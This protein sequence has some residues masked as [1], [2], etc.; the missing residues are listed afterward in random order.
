MNKNQD[1]SVE[2]VLL[3]DNFTMR[4]VLRTFLHVLAKRLGLIFR[5]H[6]SAD[7][8]QGLGYVFTTKPQ[9]IIVD[10]TLPKYSGREVI[11]YLATNPTYTSEGRAVVVLYDREIPRG[12]P[13]NYI[14]LDKG[15]PAFVTALLATLAKLMEPLSVIKEQDTVKYKFAKL[16]NFAVGLANKSDLLIRKIRAGNILVKPLYLLWLAIQLLISFN[17]SLLRILVGDRPDDNVGQYNQDVM[18]FRVQHYPTLV[19]LLVALIFLIIQLIGF[20][21]SGVAIFSISGR[22]VPTEAFGN[23]YSYR[24]TLTIDYTKVG[25]SANLT[26]FPVL[27]SGTYSYLATVGN[28]G[29][30]T[31]ANGY[32]IIFT[33]DSAGSTKLDHEIESYNATTGEVVFWVEVPSVSYTAN[34][35]I[36]MF[37]GNNSISTSQ[38]AIGNTWSSAHDFVWHMAESS[39]S[40]RNSAAPGTYDLIRDGPAAAAGKINGAQGF[41]GSDDY[42]QGPPPGDIWGN[43]T[44]SFTMQAQVYIIESTQSSYWFNQGIVYSEAISTGCNTPSGLMIQYQSA[45]VRKL[46]FWMPHHD[47]SSC[48]VVTELEFTPSAAITTWYDVAITYNASG[49]AM[50][51]YL[52]GTQVDTDTWGGSGLIDW[53]YNYAYVAIDGFG[54]RLDEVRFSSDVKTAG[55]IQTSYNSNNSPSTFYTLGAEDT[56]SDLQ[57]SARNSQNSTLLIPTITP[58][59]VG[60]TFVLTA[61]TNVTVTEIT[62]TEQGTVDAQNSLDNIKLV[63][64]LD[65]SAPYD[66]ASE[67][68]IGS[69]TQFGST[70]TDGFSSASG[71]SSFT[72]S[73]ALSTTQTMCVYVLMDVLS[74]ASQNQ[75][76]EI[77]ITDPSTQV[78]LSS[79]SVT[80][81]T[82][83]ALPGTTTLGYQTTVSASGSQVVALGIPVVNYEVG[84]KFA[85]ASF[86]GSRNVTSITITEQGTVDGQNN[87]ENIS[88]FYKFDTSAPY[89]C[90]SES[91]NSI[92]DVQFGSTDTN[93]FSGPNGTSTFTGSAAIST[94]SAMCVFVFLDVKSGTTNQTTLEI[95]IANPSTDVVVSGGVAPGPNTPVA[96]PGTTVLTVPPT[97]SLGRTGTQ[98]N[99]ITIGKTNQY[100]GGAFVLTTANSQATLTR[101]TLDEAGTVDAATNLKNI[102]MF[103]EIDSVAPYNCADEAYDGTETQ[104]GLTD[105]DGFSAT[106]GY[107][108]FIGSVTFTTSQAFCAYFV[109]D[110]QS[111]ATNGQ[112]L[113]IQVSSTS[114]INFVSGNISPSGSLTIVGTTTLRVANT[115]LN[116]QVPG[117]TSNGYDTVGSSTFVSTNPLR[118]GGKNSSGQ[119]ITAGLRF[120]NVTIARGVEILT[121]KPDF[122][123]AFG[124]DYST[125]VKTKVYG[126]AANT[127][128]VFSNSALPRSRVKTTANVDWD[129]SGTVGAIGTWYSASGNS[130]LPEVKSIIQEIVDRSGWASGNALSLIVTDDGSSNDWYWEPRAYAFAAASAPKLSITYATTRLITSASGTQTNSFANNITNQYLGGK[131]VL[132]PEDARATVTGITI[133]EQGTID[134]SANLK[135]IKLFYE[136]DTSAPYNCGSES[137]SGSETQFGSTVAAGFN[138][139]NGTAAFTG[140]VNVTTSQA[141][142]VY[143][144]LDIQSGAASGETI[145]VQITT[146]STQ[147]TVLAGVSVPAAAVALPGTSTIVLPS[148]PT[149]TNVSVN[150]GSNI[151]LNEATTTTVQVTATVTDTNGYADISNVI[152]KLYRSGVTNAH[153]CTLNQANCYQETGFVLSGCSGNSC[154]A[155]LTFS[156]QFF[157]DP[158]DT[159]TYSS[160]YWLGWVQ[161]T[162]ASATSGTAF[163]PNSVTEMNTLVALNITGSIGYGNLLPGDNTGATNQSITIVNTGN[164]AMDIELYGT[165]ICSDYPTCTAGVITVGNQEY[166]LTTFTYGSGIDLTGSP[167]TVQVN[168]AKP[169]A[170]PSNS[171]APLYWGLGL[172]SGLPSGSYTGSNSIVAVQDS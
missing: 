84:G 73:L 155:T 110:I 137:Y 3:D 156:V 55:W 78:V 131:F 149:V 114:T 123:E 44:S 122:Q 97:V 111:G 37:Y 21:A 81:G 161:A 144:V 72:G 75:T 2:I 30:V 35:G 142:C 63:Y 33:S 172:P 42:F 54:G 158:T 71:T 38:E 98:L 93:G 66:C 86:S 108:E 13:A 166:K 11:E 7:G 69:E 57:V 150:A 59:H 128:A 151:T 165:S 25:G 87:I 129:S 148:P 56:G 76:I 36:Y 171:S 96:I 103:Y 20:I 119:V 5:I 34:T 6:T 120:A 62:I 10:T 40:I 136:L 1:N 99:S 115:T 61:S 124:G 47:T 28:G 139:A 169:S 64:D 32:D 117:S 107:S 19:T 94:T 140:S 45:S 27:V 138:A 112:T 89:N 91:Y 83:V 133:A 70:D 22:V 113:E 88:M 125:L 53:F 18:A 109:M 141:M 17:I 143:V 157:A 85:I 77:E 163:S 153:T 24:R 82:A 100:I 164:V 160:Q 147:T 105:A 92:T 170:A 4:Y 49:G 79:G 134:A 130:N 15:Q 118:V 52:N 65:T 168:L 39:G 31:N 68:Y 132:T 41:D 167:V 29:R 102:K 126:E 116:L 50:V 104:F 127:S 12:L 95:E 145:E 154:T 16:A 67:F 23:G 43:S 162:D 152:G 60:G 121:A 90:D 80:P 159:G 146:P 74:S 101:F 46:N 58:L 51:A 135:N 14:L 106:N 48:A 9:L 26:N 8:V